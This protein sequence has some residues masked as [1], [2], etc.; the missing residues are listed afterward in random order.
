MIQLEK[1]ILRNICLKLGCCA[2][3]NIEIN[4]EPFVYSCVNDVISVAELSRYAVFYKIRVS[5][6]VPSS[7]PGIKN[8]QR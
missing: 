1:D 4:I 7:A 3:K 8:G 2:A 6:V 5:G